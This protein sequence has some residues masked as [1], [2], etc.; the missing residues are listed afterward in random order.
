MEKKTEKEIKSW[1]VFLIV[2]GTLWITGLHRPIIAQVHRLVL[3]TGIIQPDTDVA[4]SNTKVGVL[5]LLD[6]SG[7]VVDLNDYN[8]KVVFVNFWA[9][10]CPP[11]IA[12]MPGIQNLYESVDAN[13]VQFAIISLDDD[14]EKAT[15]FKQKK[16]YTFPIF[17]LASQL[18]DELEAD[19]LPTT[20]VLDQHGIIKMKHDGMAKYDSDSFKEFLSTLT[21]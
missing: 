14:F 12:E 7:K 15:A 8:G 18:P 16:G 6:E 21:K 4:D 9:T 2:I 1:V 10:W 20:Y 17:T 3:W 11:C 5:K 13:K 19:V